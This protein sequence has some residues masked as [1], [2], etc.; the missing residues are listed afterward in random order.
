M[1]VAHPLARCDGVEFHSR[2]AKKAVIA[3]SEATK[4]SRASIDVF[5]SGLLRPRLTTRARNDGALGAETV[6]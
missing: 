2:P 1:D 6:P 4:P 5:C 3:R